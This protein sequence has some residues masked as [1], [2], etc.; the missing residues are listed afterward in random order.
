MSI[1]NLMCIVVLLTLNLSTWGGNYAKP[2]VLTNLI[3]VANYKYVNISLTWT[4]SPCKTERRR[5][6]TQILNIAPLVVRMQNAT[7]WA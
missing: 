4:I 3:Q 5:L 7:I 6:F 2:D 1:T